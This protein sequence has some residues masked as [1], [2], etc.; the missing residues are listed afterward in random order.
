MDVQRISEPRPAHR[1]ASWVAV[2]AVVLL[3][4]CF[5]SGCSRERQSGL[6][7]RVT[8]LDVFGDVVGYRNAEVIVRDEGGEAQVAVVHSDADGR[9]R[10][11]LEPGAYFVDLFTGPFPKKPTKTMSVQVRDGTTSS[12]PTYQ[13]YYERGSEIRNAVFY[14]IRRIVRAEVERL[15][16]ER[17]DARFTLY[18]AHAARTEALFGPVDLPADRHVYVVFLEGEPT[19][20]SARGDETRALRAGGYVAL[21]LSADD[22]ETRAT[23]VSDA[24]FDL[25]A[26]TTMFPPGVGL[27][28]AY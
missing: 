20:S 3:V 8:G 13:G 26:A 27:F 22:F 11:A 28:Y 15:A 19:A 1:A 5:S 24:P 18:G 17:D 14:R 4:V 2:V 21:L 9:Y 12:L 16:L 10:I 23:T 7:G 6:E 25:E